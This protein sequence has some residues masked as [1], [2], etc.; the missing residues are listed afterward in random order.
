M[1]DSKK[2]IK[3]TYSSTNEKKLEDVLV[4][5]IKVHKES[6]SI[7]T[8]IEENEIIGEYG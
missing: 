2:N 7:S 4:N 6:A 5:L 1:N 3:V 8:T